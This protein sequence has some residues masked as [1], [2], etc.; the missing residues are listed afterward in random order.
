[1]ESLKENTATYSKLA[2]IRWT[3]CLGLEQQ[4]VRHAVLEQLQASLTGTQ[5]LLLGSVALMLS[6]S[7]KKLFNLHLL[8]RIVVEATTTTVR[9]PTYSEY[10]A[11]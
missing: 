2:Q 4:V 7:E 3:S 6:L 5:F 1:M 10:L 11:S 8:Q 9:I